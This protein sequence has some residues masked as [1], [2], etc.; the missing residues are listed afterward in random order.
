M[1]VLVSGCDLGLV[2]VSFKDFRKLARRLK[3]RYLSME[4]GSWIEV[5]GNE[6]TMQTLQR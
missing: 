1:R 5:E 4:E 3:L 6:D 2:P